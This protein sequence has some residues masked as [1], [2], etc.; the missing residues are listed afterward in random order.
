[1][2]VAD[3]YAQ[4]STM[5]SWRRRLSVF[6]NGAASPRALFNDRDRSA[7]LARRRLTRAAGYQLT[8]RVRAGADR[9]GREHEAG[10]RIA[11]AQRAALHEN[12]LAGLIAQDL[13][14]RAGGLEDG[15]DGGH[16]TRT[17]INV[18]RLDRVARC[19]EIQTANQIQIVPRRIRGHAS[20][21]GYHRCC[22]ADGRER[23]AARVDGVRLHGP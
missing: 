10:A 12:K 9:E 23:A 16:R 1:M 15:A 5:R 20:P 13:G 6:R 17:R 22:S 14:G 18:Q 19:F 8:G 4:C 2:P 21:I 11:D 7:A 3:P